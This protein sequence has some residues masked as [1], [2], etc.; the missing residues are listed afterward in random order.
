MPPRA[1]KIS[2]S[3][4]MFTNFMQLLQRPSDQDLHYFLKIIYPGS[5][6]DN[7]IKDSLLPKNCQTDN[8]I[9]SKHVTN[10]IND[11]CHII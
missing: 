9:A 3:N 10:Q 8:A 11:M 2:S 7:V 1:L 4:Y 5:V 6:P